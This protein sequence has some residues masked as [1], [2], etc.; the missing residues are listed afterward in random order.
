MPRLSAEVQAQRRAVWEQAMTQGWAD[1][2]EAMAQA[3]ADY[4]QKVAPFEEAYNKA[5][6]EAEKR[7]TGALNTAWDAW[8]KGA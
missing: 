5:R 8:R 7:L 6:S 4:H 2:D 1:F 3:C